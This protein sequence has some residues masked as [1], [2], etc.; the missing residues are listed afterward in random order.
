MHFGD[1]PVARIVGTNCKDCSVDQVTM[2][3]LSEL[4]PSGW[5]YDSP[6]WLNLQV[7]GSVLQEVNVTSEKLHII[8]I[9]FSSCGCI[10]CD[11]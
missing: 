4:K 2:G 8:T 1:V 3:A 11:Q 7:A 5:S 9:S 6:P 10:D